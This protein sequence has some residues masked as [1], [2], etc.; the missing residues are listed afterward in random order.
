[1]GGFRAGPLIFAV[2]SLFLL[3]C[4]SQALPCDSQLNPYAFEAKTFTQNRLLPNGM[5][6]IR[7]PETDQ[8]ISPHISVHRVM[9]VVPGLQDDLPESKDIHYRVVEVDGTIGWMTY[10]LSAHA[11]FYG[12]G[13]DSLG[14]PEKTWIDPEEDGINGNE[15]LNGMPESP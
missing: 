8:E 13:E 4:P 6:A 1:M 14:F 9:M 2:S 5:M 12:V 15:H 10:L 3:A 7:Y 11:L